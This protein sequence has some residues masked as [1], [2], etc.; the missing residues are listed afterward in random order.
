[1]AEAA[2]TIEGGVAAFHGAWAHGHRPTAVVAM[3]DAI[4]VG[5]L[6]AART[7]GLRIPEDLSIVGF[8]DLDFAAYTDPP[9]TTVHQPIRKKGEAA[10]RLLVSMIGGAVTEP[11]AIPDLETYLVVRGSTGPSLSVPPQKAS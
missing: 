11:T 5:A 10:M 1:M 8:D 3:S 9:L 6:A 2:S 4:A 7:R